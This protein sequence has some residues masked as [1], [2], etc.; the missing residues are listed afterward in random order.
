MRLSVQAAAEE[1][2][3]EIALLVDGEA[4]S[5][6]ALAVSVRHAQT[7]LN[8]RGAFD[9]ERVALVAEPRFECLVTMLALIEA[10]MPVVLLHPRWTE[11]ERLQFL[12]PCGPARELASLWDP[13][14]SLPGLAPMRSVAQD[15]ERPLAILATSGT[16]GRP[17]GVELSRRAFVAS[18]EASADCLGW[19]DDDRWLLAMPPAH[20]GGLSILTRCLLARRTVVVE[21]Q[22]RFDP[23][24]VVET[25]E[26]RKVTMLSV[27]PTMLRQLVDHRPPGHLRA[28]L[29]GG[30][31]ASVELRRAA[32]DRGWPVLATYGLTE[33]CSQVATQRPG[34]QTDDK[35]DCGQ[36]L[37]GIEVR[38]TANDGI[39]VRGDCVL[40][41]YLPAE[42]TEPFS[43][44]GWLR[45][46]DRGWVDESGRLHVLGRIDDLI[47]S[48]GE[49]VDPVEVEQALESHPAIRA[50][51][52]FG[53]PDER[54]GQ[55]VAV[56]VE[57]TVEPTVEPLPI[58]QLTAH[59]APRLA[60]FKRPR[61]VA[62]TPRMDRSESGKVDRQATAEWAASCLRPWGED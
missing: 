52:V 22:P 25:I 29:L 13:S 28:V 14:V 9:A 36:P 12:E 8:L 24:V 44:D 46:N 48:G 30:A 18:A 55:A 38:I 49:N 11:R 43:D 45:T 50:A 37:A 15:D 41:R 32:R 60:G 10:G 23:A 51:C 17:K 3:N 57:P 42:S 4:I 31:A 6:A 2:P 62:V 20:I 59:L 7:W 61:F 19:Q 53:I 1:A 27:V 34:Q 5:F 26:R 16:T 35:G 39:E 21:R 33:T 56:V 54:W 47:V 40:S 58:A